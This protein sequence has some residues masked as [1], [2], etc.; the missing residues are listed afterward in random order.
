[1]RAMTRSAFLVLTQFF[2]CSKLSNLSME[3]ANESLSLMLPHSWE[4][5]VFPAWRK[6]IHFSPILQEVSIF[7]LFSL[8]IDGLKRGFR[9][10]QGMSLQSIIITSHVEQRLPLSWGLANVVQGHGLV[11]HLLTSC[12]FAHLGWGGG[13][14]SVRGMATQAWQTQVW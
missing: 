5:S 10:I 8:W 14:G 4:T 9:L 12:Y 2:V 3:K 1:M 13:E 7:I 6:W 11:T